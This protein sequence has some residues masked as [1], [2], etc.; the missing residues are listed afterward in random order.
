MFKNTD[1][2]GSLESNPYK[3]QR[4]DIGDYSLFVNGKHIPN[5]CL[6]LGMDHEKSPSCGT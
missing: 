4:Y 2:F 5:E 6:Y 3:F 1:I